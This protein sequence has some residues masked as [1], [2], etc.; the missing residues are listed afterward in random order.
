M[1]R[2]ASVGSGLD[3]VEFFAN[4]ETDLRIWRMAAHDLVILLEIVECQN[5]L[6]ISSVSCMK[7]PL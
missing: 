4:H 6:Q 7:G 5:W 1:V 2:R 3:Y